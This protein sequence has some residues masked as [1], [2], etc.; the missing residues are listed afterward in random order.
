MKLLVVLVV[1]VVAVSAQNARRDADYP[2]PEI[3]AALKPAHD[4]CVQK[5]GVT[6]EAIKEFSDGKIHEDEN[7]KCYMVNLPLSRSA[8]FRCSQE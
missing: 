7:L 4:T 5:T 2:P 6:E 1:A 3:L 8:L